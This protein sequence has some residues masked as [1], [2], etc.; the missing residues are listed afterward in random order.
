MGKVS[1]T[2]DKNVLLRGESTPAAPEM[3]LQHYQLTPATN[4]R[5]DGMPLAM[6]RNN[7]SVL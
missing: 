4:V 5:E 2:K 6:R 3:R 1:E 7:S